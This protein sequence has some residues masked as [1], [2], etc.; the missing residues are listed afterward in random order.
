[1]KHFCN[2]ILYNYISIQHISTINKE[3]KHHKMD[4]VKGILPKKA[5]VHDNVC[6]INKES[7]NFI[8][9]DFLISFC[10]TFL[11]VS[12]PLVIS[13]LLMKMTKRT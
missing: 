5:I 8:Y 3:Y 2:N 12:M 13:D 7:V 9:Q 11:T 6:I 4:S 1:V 10:S